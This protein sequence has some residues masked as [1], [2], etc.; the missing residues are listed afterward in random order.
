MTQLMKW[1]IGGF[2]CFGL[3]AMPLSSFASDVASFR[4][5]Q[6]SVVQP[7]ITA[8]LEIL[9]VD[10]YKA[11]NI[12]SD[13]L[14]VSI[15]SQQAIIDDLKDFSRSGAG[16]GL[17][18]LVDIS[19][20]LTEREF[21]QMRTVLKTWI[22]A[23]S[24]KDKTAIMTFG[25]DVKLVKDF[26]DN[27]EALNVIVDNLRPTDNQTQL[28]SGLV[29]AM[30]L[31]RRT[32]P[33]IPLRRAII[34]L[35]DGED[36]FPGGMT[37]QEVVDRMRIDPVPIYAV[38]FY[39]PPK[40]S[41]KEEFLKI[42]G[43]FA[44]TSGGAYFRAEANNLS[45]IFSKT[46]QKIQD[47]YE[48]DLTCKGC[49]WDGA[50]RRLQIALSSGSKILN[51]GMDIRLFAKTEKKPERV[52][53]GSTKEK[54]QPGQPEMKAPETEQPKKEVKKNETAEEESDGEDKFPFT[55]W[56][57]LGGGI[58]VL[59]I[60]ILV[61]VIRRKRR[62][63]EPLVSDLLVSKADPNEANSAID[64]S[65][66]QVGLAAKEVPLVPPVPPVPPPVGKRLRFTVIRDSS[67][68]PFEVDLYDRLLIGRSNDCDIAL[69]DD[70]EASRV[71]CELVFDQGSINIA[72]L[73]SKNGTLVNGVPITGRYQIKNDDIILV[74]KTELR[75]NIL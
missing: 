27:R 11:E 39:Q 69:A 46:R 55:W 49:N 9:D 62:L 18:L 64:L 14:N 30:E 12:R 5:S 33:G 20:S 4:L 15:G 63:R 58:G 26:T 61:L 75:F 38:G 65:A 31:G 7:G 68:V 70:K 22:N 13:Q 17:I 41:R 37:K 72:D 40:P 35:T 44:R 60:V 3:F 73:G 28:H 8:Y 51:A 43:E 45:E 48:L 10:G 36:D 42:L 47:V 71:H 74:G 57:Y 56:V 54:K 24:G 67:R 32:D 50:T 59:C 52:A 16:T 19:N 34:T 25:K 23:M 53:A 66:V 21:A 2:V 29:Q 6:V 1:I